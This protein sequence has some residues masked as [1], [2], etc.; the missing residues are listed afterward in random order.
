M[1]DHESIIYRYSIIRP[2]RRRGG[3]PVEQRLDK[4]FG[5]FISVCISAARGDIIGGKKEG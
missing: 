1:S 5:Y 2:V 3:I 4:L